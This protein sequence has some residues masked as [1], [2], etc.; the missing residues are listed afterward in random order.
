[1][2]EHPLLRRV[3][4]LLEVSIEKLEKERL[5]F[6]RR[7]ELKT[8]L[9]Q[10][11]KVAQ[12]LCGRILFQALETGELSETTVRA[13]RD[14]KPYSQRDVLGRVSYHYLSSSQNR[15]IYQESSPKLVVP[16]DDQFP[17]INGIQVHRFRPVRPPLWQGGKSRPNPNRATY[18][19]ELTAE[20]YGVDV[21]HITDFTYDVD[22]LGG[23]VDYRY[24][25][26]DFN[27][28]WASP[29]SRPQILSEVEDLVTVLGKVAG[30]TTPAEY[31]QG[32]D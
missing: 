6:E 26:E 5:A 1:M 21:K 14:D 3:D 13:K 12:G 11:I 22:R 15:T 8:A 24:S 27:P 18:I 20:L 9:H 7:K 19:V 29:D 4:T 31:Q 17:P 23:S 10:R 32:R 2:A 25:F 16:E 30:V 28:N